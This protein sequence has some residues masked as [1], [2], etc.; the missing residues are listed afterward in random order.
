MA[1]LR[2][3]VYRGDSMAG[4][5]RPGDS[6]RVVPLDGAARVGDVVVYRD[7]EGRRIVHRVVGVDATGSLLTKGDAT[8]ARDDEP[9]PP[10]RVEGRVASVVPI[11]A[12]RRVPIALRPLGAAYRALARRAWLRALLRALFRVE[13]RVVR[14]RRGDGELVKVL[15]RGR[16]VAELFPESGRMRTRVPWALLVDP[17]APRAGARRDRSTPTRADRG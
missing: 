8:D 10:S 6:L 16:A 14:F 1:E 4:T 7:E 2:L 12:P 17:P 11:A 3:V 5:F 9:V 13:L 15:H